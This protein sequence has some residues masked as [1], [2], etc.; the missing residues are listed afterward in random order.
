MTKPRR[1][2]RGF[3]GWDPD[4]RFAAA[5]K[6]GKS[7]PADKRTFA[8]DPAK[9]AEAGRKGGTTPKGQGDKTRG[10]YWKS[11]PKP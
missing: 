3:A 1:S 10:V 5:M 9:A 7:V 8:R 11:K 6:G 4:K 2:R